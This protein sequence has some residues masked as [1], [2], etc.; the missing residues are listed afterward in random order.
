MDL[1]RGIRPAKARW[2]Q[3][4]LRTLL[5]FILVCSLAM[6]ALSVRLDHARKQRAA[7]NAIC[8]RGGSVQ[9]DYNSFSGGSPDSWEYDYDGPSPNMPS[10][11]FCTPERIRA[12]E[13]EPLGPRWLRSVLGDDL[14]R[15]PVAAQVYDDVQL[16]HLK[17][18]TRIRE[19][20]AR[21]ET[22]TDAG[23]GN[24]KDMS[25]IEGLILECPNVTD[26]GLEKLRVLVQLKRLCLAWSRASDAGFGNL[27]GL[28]K[29]EMLALQKTQITGAGLQHVASLTALRR[30]NLRGTR[31]T[32]TG[33][34]HLA[35][36]TRLQSLDLADTPITDAGIRHLS[37]LISL[38]ELK[39]ANT[40]VAAL[41]S[42]NWRR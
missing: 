1:R 3:F 30:L 23:L 2:C 33:L 25:Q 41:A 29:L 24:L 6:S 4:S 37:S 5:L 32:D 35:A 39:L 21:G 38:R 15:A 9:Y 36:L 20:D 7:V 26:A 42:H 10:L 31:V 8:A 22:I 19:L 28:A 17:R 40:R 16:A 18:L 12:Q 14:F 13:R 27:E 11:Y 34:R